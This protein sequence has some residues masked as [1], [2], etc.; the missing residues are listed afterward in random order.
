MFSIGDLVKIEADKITPVD[1]YGVVVGFDREMYGLK[2]FKIDW[3]DG[4]NSSES[5]NDVIKVETDD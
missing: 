3:F 4:Q 1:V 2:F 5:V